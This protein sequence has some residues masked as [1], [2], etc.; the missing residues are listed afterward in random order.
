MKKFCKRCGEE[1]ERYVSDGKC[2]PCRRHRAKIYSAA[3]KAQACARSARWYALNKERAMTGMRRRRKEHPEKAAVLSMHC[4]AR[5][6]NAPGSHTAKERK[7]VMAMFGGRCA[8]CSSQATTADHMTPLS[9]GG[10]NDAA[11][12]APACRPCNSKKGTMTFEEYLLRGFTPLV[13]FKEQ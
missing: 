9:R 2:K 13:A 8:Y 1:T 12:L 3:H 6:V 5:K 10:S 7:Q 4:R 11:N